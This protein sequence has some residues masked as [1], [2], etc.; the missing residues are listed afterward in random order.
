MLI[1]ISQDNNYSHSAL[2]LPWVSLASLIVPKYNKF[3]KYSIRHKDDL[4]RKPEF[5]MY[6]YN[7]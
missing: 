7:P 1:V 6:I 4:K 3:C 2:Y 5:Y